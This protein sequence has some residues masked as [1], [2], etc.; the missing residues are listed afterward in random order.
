MEF[1]GK[2]CGSPADRDKLVREK[3]QKE[4]EMETLATGDA[5]QITAELLERLGYNADDI[6][7]DKG[8]DV[9][10]STHSGLCSTDFII[11]LNNR[12]FMA[13]KCNM[14]VDSR[15]RHI[16]SFCRAAD[17]KI[18]PLAVVTDGLEFRVMDTMSGKILSNTPDDAPDRESALEYLATNPE[19]SYPEEKAIK[20]RQMLLAFETTVCPN[21]GSK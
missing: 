9:S 11:K 13:I 8:F 18:I 16:L 4:D 15:E 14:A 2:S 3:I 20:A 7:R 21:T 17:S 12:R 19:I 6:E 1:I 10:T 5:R